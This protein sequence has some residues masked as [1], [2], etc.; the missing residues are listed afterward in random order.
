MPTDE[1][2]RTITFGN[3]P[4]DTKS[5]YIIAVI[6]KKL[7][8]AQEELDADGVYAFGKKSTVRGAA[9]FKTQEAMMAYLRRQTQKS[10]SRWMDTGFI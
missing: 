10:S 5:E 8:L 9:R 4:E 2:Q 7:E 3:F 1:K 6:K